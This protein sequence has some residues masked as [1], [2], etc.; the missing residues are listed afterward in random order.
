[1]NSKVHW[2][3]TVCRVKCGFTYIH[4]HVHTVC[5]FT[6]IHMYLHANVHV[7]WV[8]SVLKY[9]WRFILNVVI[10]TA[11]E[12]GRLLE[13]FYISF[14]RGC[15]RWKWQRILSVTAHIHANLGLVCL[16]LLVCVRGAY[17]HP[18]HSSRERH[19][20]EWV[21]KGWPW[22]MSL[23]WI[24]HVCVYISLMSHNSAYVWGKKLCFHLFMYLCIM[25]FFPLNSY[26]FMCSAV[27]LTFP[28]EL[29]W[30]TGCEVGSQIS[31]VGIQTSS[32]SCRYLAFESSG[33]S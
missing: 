17:S 3:C 1:M 21:E 8:V 5:M 30:Y 26:L 9:D 16:C 19:P 11:W 15:L 32:A 12:E 28:I 18:S 20:G 6:N 14:Q 23:T 2:W 25:E 4:I 33:T 10:V 31:S 24:I 27:F 22:I 13:Y 29:F 7:F